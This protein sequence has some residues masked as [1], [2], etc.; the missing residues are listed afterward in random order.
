[1]FVKN[2]RDGRW[3][4]GSTGTVIELAEDHVKV[5]I[6]RGHTVE[7]HSEK[8]DRTKPYYDKSKRKIVH[9]IL[10]SFVQ[11]PIKLAWAITIHKCQ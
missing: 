11:L 9:R 6:D 10:G 8:W 7:V 3:V 2:D 1:M 4:N 5:R